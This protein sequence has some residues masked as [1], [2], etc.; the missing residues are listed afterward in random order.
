MLKFDVTEKAIDAAVQQGFLSVSRDYSEF[1]LSRLISAIFD[2]TGTPESGVIEVQWVGTMYAPLFGS[3]VPIAEVAYKWNKSKLMGAYLGDRYY[4]ADYP[5][6]MPSD[7]LRALQSTPYKYAYVM[8]AKGHIMRPVAKNHWRFDH[9]PALVPAW[10]RFVNPAY[11]APDAC[12]LS[13]EP[14]HA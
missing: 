6:G 1:C 3:D 9:D 7:L 8:A 10:T 5:S 4:D 13:E 2:L 12:Y 14:Q 11:T